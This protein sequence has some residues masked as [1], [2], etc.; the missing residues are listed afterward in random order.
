MAWC[1][2]SGVGLNRWKPV[3][4]R[5]LSSWVGFERT[6]V[7]TSRA[8]RS[9]RI[10]VGETRRVPSALLFGAEYCHRTPP[11]QSQRDG[12]VLRNHERMAI[13]GFDNVANMTSAVMRVD[14]PSETWQ[15]AGERVI[16]LPEEPADTWRPTRIRRGSAGHC[17]RDLKLTEDG[18]LS[19]AIRLVSEAPSPHGSGGLGRFWPRPAGTGLRPLG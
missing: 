9:L 19:G 13:F 5:N 10:P 16:R 15:L 4:V 3:K 7:P 17:F 8:L 12:E 1:E 11:A 18:C 14:V 2:R 6:G